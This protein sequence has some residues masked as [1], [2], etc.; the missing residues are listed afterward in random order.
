[1]QH[2]IDAV[3]ALYTRYK[4]VAPTS[5]DVLPQSGS[6]RRYFR[7]HGPTD[8]VIGTYGNNIKENETFFYFSE[9]FKKKGLA[10]PEILAIS[11]DRQFYLQ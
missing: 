1:M 5:L 6:E 3:T 7:I 10:V 11:E 8:S 9:H 4:G 2:W